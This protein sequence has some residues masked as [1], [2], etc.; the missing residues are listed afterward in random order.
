VIKSNSNAD[1]TEELWLIRTAP[2]IGLYISRLA[3][4]AAFCATFFRKKVADKI[5]ATNL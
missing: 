2:G 3:G 5:V 4:R 1:A